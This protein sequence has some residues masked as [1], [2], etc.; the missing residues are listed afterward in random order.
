MEAKYVQNGQ[1]GQ[2]IILAVVF[3]TVA[4]LTV[5]VGATLPIARQLQIGRNAQLSMQSYYTAEAGSEDAYYRIKNN[6]TRSFPE[7]LAVGGA[8]ATIT[9]ATVGFNEQENLSEGNIQNIIRD[10]V[11]DIIV[12]NGF[13]F[14][15]AMQAGI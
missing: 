15:Y 8:N 5:I 4:V 10:V 2:V 9:L 14:T 13:D 1:R 7:S 3:F 12:T 11:K 6:L